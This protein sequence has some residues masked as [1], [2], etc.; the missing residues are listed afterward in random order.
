[1]QPIPRY[2]NHGTTAHKTSQLS[3]FTKEKSSSS[4]MNFSSLQQV[5]RP[6]PVHD[7]KHFDCINADQKHIGVLPE[8][9]FV[10][11]NDVSKYLSPDD[12]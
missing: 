11:Q 1:M 6:T 4:T 5:L 2:L 12:V 3:Q 8:Q 9:K 10:I 7:R